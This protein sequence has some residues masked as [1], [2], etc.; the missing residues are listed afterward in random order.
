MLHLLHPHVKGNRYKGVNFVFLLHI[1]LPAIELLSSRYS[2]LK[3]VLYFV[4]KNNIQRFRNKT[5]AAQ[6]TDG[7]YLFFV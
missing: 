3:P 1:L 5:S 4:S 7:G 2:P 6:G